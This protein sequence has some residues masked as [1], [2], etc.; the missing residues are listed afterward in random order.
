MDWTKVVTDP[1]G[2]AGFALAM[3]GLVSKLA[4]QKRRERWIVPAFYTM[5]LICVVGG[6]VLA[7]HRESNITA[8]L[9]HPVTTPPITSIQTGNIEQTVGNG[10]AVAGIHGNVTVNPPVAGKESEQKQKGR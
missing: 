7:Y 9:K 4:A 10:A 2:L 6:L 1:L 8:S 3:V 5:A